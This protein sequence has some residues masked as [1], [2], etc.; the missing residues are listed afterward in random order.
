[1][2]SSTSYV[3][4][5]GMS[6]ATKILSTKMQPRMLSDYESSRTVTVVI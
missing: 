5:S 6:F 3:A 2:Q 1:M 4:I